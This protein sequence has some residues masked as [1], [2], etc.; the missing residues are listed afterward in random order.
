M[1][2]TYIRTPEIREKIRLS[3]I[4]KHFGYKHSE[5]IK[6]L[7]SLSKRNGRNPQWKGDEVGYLAL[8]DWIKRHLPKTPC[9]CGNEKVDL[10]NISGKYLRDLKDWE[11]LCRSCHM[12]LDGRIKNL[13]QYQVQEDLKK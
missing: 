9:V 5:P 3:S 10:H 11:Y 7:I 8:H 6:E 1:R 4:G 12:R 2:G 13:K